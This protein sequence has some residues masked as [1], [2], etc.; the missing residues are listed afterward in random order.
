MVCEKSYFL[1]LE[2]KKVADYYFKTSKE[3]ITAVV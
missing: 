3:S 2:T 1:T